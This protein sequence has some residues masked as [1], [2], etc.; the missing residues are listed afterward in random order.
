PRGEL[1]VLRVHPDLRFEDWR[2]G[3]FRLQT[4]ATEADG[5]RVL[6]LLGGGLE[7]PSAESVRPQARVEAPG[8]EYQAKQLAWW[9]VQPHKSS[10][11]CQLTVEALRG[12][13][14]QLPL[15]LPAGWRVERVELSPARQLR[16]WEVRQ[17]R[18][19]SVLLVDLDRPLTP[20]AA[21]GDSRFGTSPS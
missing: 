6:T 21:A 2:P 12:R 18:G 8:V 15:D 19:V 5:T 1:L 20:R 17:E 16:D 10:L 14:F 3:R 9:Q 13:L 7:A 11:T 4:T